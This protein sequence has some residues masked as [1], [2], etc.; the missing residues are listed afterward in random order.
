VT[1]FISRTQI[2]DLSSS[3]QMAAPSPQSSF[4][5]KCNLSLL[6]RP[7]RS[8]ANL[9][10]SL[11]KITTQ[12]VNTRLFNQTLGGISGSP[13][14]FGFARSSSLS[15]SEGVKKML[16]IRWKETSERTSESWEENFNQ[17]WAIVTL[18]KVEGRKDNP[19]H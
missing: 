11:S 18:E 15:Q 5:R 9:T 7:R 12:G 6:L 8:S 14:G 13:D 16:R 1:V 3:L 10:S 2:K 4:S 19:M 17:K